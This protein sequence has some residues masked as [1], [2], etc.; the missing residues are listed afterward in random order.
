MGD[1]PVSHDTGTRVRTYVRVRCRMVTSRRAFLSLIVRESD[2]DRLICLKNT[3]D[4]LI[5]F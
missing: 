2:Y 1:T 5:R 3:F 4:R